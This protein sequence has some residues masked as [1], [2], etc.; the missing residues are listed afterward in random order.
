MSNRKMILELS[1]PT[2]SG[3]MNIGPF[4][5]KT[6]EAKAV[7]FTEEQFK[8]FFEQ[9]K[10]AIDFYFKISPYEGEI[11]EGDSFLIE[12]GKKKKTKKDD[13]ELKEIL[14]EGNPKVLLAYAKNK[15]P[16]SIPSMTLK[17]VLDSLNVPYRLN[18][19]QKSL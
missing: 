5:F 1:K 2:Q 14:E 3:A 4:R 10:E 17:Q 6:N 8:N 13:Q 7:H 16:E 18:A 11:K 9:D 19:T 15:G 12:E